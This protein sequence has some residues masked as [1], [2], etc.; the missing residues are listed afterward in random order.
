MSRSYCC[1]TTGGARSG[2]AVHPSGFGLIIGTGGAFSLGGVLFSSNWCRW[3]PCFRVQLLP[4]WWGCHGGGGAQDVSQGLE[5]RDW[6]FPA[7]TPV[8]HLFLQLVHMG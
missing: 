3:F 8:S 5:S 1:R 4:G 2:T 6:G 7:G